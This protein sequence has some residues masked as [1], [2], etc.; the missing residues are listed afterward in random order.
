MMQGVTSV[1]DYAGALR[2]KTNT[3]KF[4]D[5]QYLISENLILVDMYIY[6]YI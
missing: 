4:S 2:Y 5:E 1:N 6:I 3:Y